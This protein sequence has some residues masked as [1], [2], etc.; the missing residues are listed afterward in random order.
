MPF[1]MTIYN[2]LTIQL[3]LCKE[4]LT[5]RCIVAQIVDPTPQH[6]TYQRVTLENP[7]SFSFEPLGIE[8]LLIVGFYVS[9]W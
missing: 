6:M 1:W 3:L 4:M 9:I 5:N 2:L 7:L 8:K